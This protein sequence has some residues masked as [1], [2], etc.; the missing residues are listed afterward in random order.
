VKRGTFGNISKCVAVMT[1]KGREF[2]QL[3][4]V[5]DWP[6]RYD[7]AG[8]RERGVEHGSGLRRSWPSSLLTSPTRS[9]MGATG[10]THA[11]DWRSGNLNTSTPAHR[12]TEQRAKATDRL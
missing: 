10:V 7:V 5:T 6:R 2:R 9:C 4:M 3:K 12:V 8:L 11:Q 1:A